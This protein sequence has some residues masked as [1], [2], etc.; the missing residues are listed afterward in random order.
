M[1]CSQKRSSI[2][3]GKYETGLGRAPSLI[4]Y[5]T[6]A[7]VLC[8]QLAE[9]LPAPFVKKLLT[10]DFETEISTFRTRRVVVPTHDSDPITLCR[11]R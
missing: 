9:A 5:E 2:E 1:F 11:C 10:N 3:V 4:Q 6:D 7:R 8:A